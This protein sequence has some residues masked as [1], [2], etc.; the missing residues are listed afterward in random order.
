MTVTINKSNLCGSVAAPPSKSMAHRLIIC[1]SLTKQKCKVKNIALS[2]DI[3]ATISC[4]KS[5]GADITFDKNDVIVDGSDMFTKADTLYCNESGSTLR[6][7]LPICLMQQKKATLCG[8]ERLFSRSLEVYE[9]LCQARGIGFCKDKDSVTVCGKLTD[10]EFFLRGDISSQF[11][12]GLLFVLPL[13]DGDSIINITSKLE[14]A[15]YIDMTINAQKMFGVDICRR[16]NVITVKGNQRYL[17]IDTTVEGDC[18]NAAFFEALSVLG[19]NVKVVGIDKNTYQGDIVFYDYF[20]KLKN[21]RPTLDVSDC[22]DLAPILMAVAAAKNGAVLTGTSRLKIKESD[23][24]SAMKTELAKF[25]AD[26]IIYENKIEVRGGIGCPSGHI[27]AHND[28][29]IVMACAVLLTL[30]GGSIDGAQAVNKSFPNFFEMLDN[31]GAEVK[32]ETE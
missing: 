12:S 23:R 1:A 2:D 13:L 10:G 15:P 8:S 24:G 27:D 30:F 7:M 16:E 28:H 4:L 20:E 31:L 29:R 6:F 14:S 17:P 22:P 11:I 19:H 18:S 25:G 32:Y 9:Q 21:G 5:L 3:K 26:V